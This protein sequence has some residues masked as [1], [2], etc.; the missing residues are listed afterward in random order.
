MFKETSVFHN[1]FFHF[2][3]CSTFLLSV[4]VMSPTPSAQAGCGCTKPPPELA[5]V[6]PNATYAGT[7]ITVFHPDFKSGKKYAVTFTSGVEGDSETQDAWAIVRRDLADGQQKPQLVV[8]LPDLPLGPTSVSVYVAGQNGAFIAL[9]DSVLTVVP[10]PVMIDNNGDSSEKN[11]RAA[12][13]R[14][15]V[16]YFSLDVSQ[17]KEPRV[18]RAQAEGYPP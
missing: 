11:F 6:R 5:T 13:S 1:Q 10:Q 7:D 18:F 3:V 2:A 8:P 12:V 16:V 15:G 9:D 14:S 4:A 17:I